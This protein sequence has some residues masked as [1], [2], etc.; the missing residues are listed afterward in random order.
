[1]ALMRATHRGD[2]SGMARGPEPVA[3]RRPDSATAGPIA[4][5]RLTGDEKKKP[6]ARR[7]RRLEP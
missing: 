5:G 6:S 1:M 7:D 4:R 3:D 2:R